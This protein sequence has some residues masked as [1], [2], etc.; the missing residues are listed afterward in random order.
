MD[1]SFAS[2][3]SLP[4]TGKNNSEKKLKLPRT[5]LSMAKTTD[6]E[7]NQK[8]SDF[9]DKKFNLPN[10]LDDGALPLPLPERSTRHIRTPYCVMKGESPEVA[11]RRMIADHETWK[12]AYIAEITK[13]YSHGPGKNVEECNSKEQRYSPKHG[14]EEDDENDPYYFDPKASVQLTK[15]ILKY[16]IFIFTIE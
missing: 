13:M 10:C 1:N 14:T 11:L 3:P 4:V 12:A 6:S 5:Q 7:D 8:D 9:L 2:F 16:L 15:V